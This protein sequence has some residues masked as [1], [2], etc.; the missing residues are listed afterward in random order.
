MLLLQLQ[1]SL[2]LILTTVVLKTI[3]VEEIIAEAVHQQQEGETEQVIDRTVKLPKRNYLVCD[4]PSVAS[5]VQ[6]IRAMISIAFVCGWD[7]NT[8]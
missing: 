8:K 2:H 5:F 6:A 3:R 1:M 7:T 4:A